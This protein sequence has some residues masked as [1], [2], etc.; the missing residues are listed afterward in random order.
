MKIAAAVK[1]LAAKASAVAIAAASALFWLALMLV[2][3][4]ALIIS[5]VHTLAG[6]GWAQIAAGVLLLGLAA[7]V[8]M[9]ARRA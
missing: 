4:S 3:A 2:G 7:L 5:G 1:W 8:L 9:G 6:P